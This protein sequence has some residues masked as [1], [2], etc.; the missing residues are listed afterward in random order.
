MDYFLQHLA[1]TSALITLLAALF[2]LVRFKDRVFQADAAVLGRWGGLPAGLRLLAFFALLTLILGIFSLFRYWS[3]I[4]KH[5]DLIIYGA[6]LFLAMA[7]GMF[8]RVIASKHEAGQPM[9]NVTAAELV[10]P[11]LFSLI[12]FYPIWGLAAN[13]P[14]G[15]FPVHAA[16]LNGYF[17]ES[18]V[19]TARWRHEQ[20]QKILEEY[21]DRPGKES[22]NKAASGGR[23]SPL[24]SGSR[25]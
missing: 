19:S 2:F 20:A 21:A 14:V 24:R 8:V 6:W 11:L 3:D 7:G 4:R 12:V 17:W 9:L 23:K 10:Y 5:G 15:L 22:P 16:F 13:A 1:L 25:R 18:V